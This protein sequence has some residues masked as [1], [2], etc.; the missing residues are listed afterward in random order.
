VGIPVVPVDVSCADVLKV[1]CAALVKGIHARVA[2][3]VGVWRPAPTYPA[4]PVCD[5]GGPSLCGR[6]SG[7]FTY[8]VV[9]CP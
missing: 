9:G 3:G 5:G 8:S 1:A 4:C 6:G 2:V 7:W